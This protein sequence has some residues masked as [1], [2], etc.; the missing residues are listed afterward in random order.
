[1]SHVVQI[2]TQ[3]RDAEAVRAACRRLGLAEPVQ[4]VVPVA[5]TSAESVQKLRQWASGRCLSADQ[6]G[7]YSSSP[8]STG[9][10][11]KVS[12]PPVDPASN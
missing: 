11:R 10:R 7:I 4:N 3:V 12:R 1:M 5:R 8:A 2:K 9:N 6:G